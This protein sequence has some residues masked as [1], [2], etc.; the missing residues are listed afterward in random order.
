[1]RGMRMGGTERGVGELAAR[2]RGNR[3]LLILG[4]CALVGFVP[5]FFIGYTDAGSLFDESTDWPPWLAIG[6]PLLLFGTAIMGGLRARRL[7]D[8]HQKLILYK[9]VNFAAF[10]FYFSYPCWFFL[11]KGGFLP[12]PMH[13]ALFGIFYLCFVIGYVY[14]RLKS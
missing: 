4:L 10:G 1:M 9:T 3:L 2:S 12:E 13:G 6:L 14:N 8:E 11:W 5:G 7:Y